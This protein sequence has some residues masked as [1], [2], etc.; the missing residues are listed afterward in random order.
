[1]ARYKGEKVHLV[2]QRQELVFL[3]DYLKYNGEEIAFIL[4]H[5]RSFVSRLLAGKPKS[6]EPRNFKKK[7]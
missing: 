4:N 2:F 6:W 5:D 1:M 7:N 3:L